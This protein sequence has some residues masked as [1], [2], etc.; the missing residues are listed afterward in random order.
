MYLLTWAPNNDSNQPVHTSS[1]IWVFVIRMKTFCILGYPKY[2]QWRFWSDW[3]KI[4]NKQSKNNLSDGMNVLL[5]LGF[6]CSHRPRRTA[7]TSL[8]YNPCEISSYTDRMGPWHV[9]F[10]ICKC[11]CSSHTIYPYS[12]S[13]VFAVRGIILSIKWFCK[14]K[15]QL[16]QCGYQANVR[17]CPCLKMPWQ[18]FVGCCSYII[19]WNRVWPRLELVYWITRWLHRYLVTGNWGQSTSLRSAFGGVR[20]SLSSLGLWI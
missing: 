16:R 9:S 17:Q 3:W 5:D 12:L 2:D 10:S 7:T 20:V 8:S 15:T 14:L 13:R 1:L 6:R 18:T 4:K 11:V 19:E